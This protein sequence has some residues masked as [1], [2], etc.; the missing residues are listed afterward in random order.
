MMQGAQKSSQKPQKE[1]KFRQMM[2]F[3]VRAVDFLSIYVKQRAYQGD[4]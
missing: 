3:K 4:S 2:D 1:D